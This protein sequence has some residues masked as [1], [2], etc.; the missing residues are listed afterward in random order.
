MSSYKE[1]CKECKEKLGFEHYV[2]HKWLDE[3]AAQSWPYKFHRAARHHEGGVEE[4]RRKWGDDAAKAAE[5]HIY[6]DLKEDGIEADRIPSPEEMC[7]LY[8]INMKS[9]E[10]AIEQGKKEENGK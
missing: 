3:L 7:K 8:H 4:V 10:L 9:L 6:A 1:H 5:L 2:V